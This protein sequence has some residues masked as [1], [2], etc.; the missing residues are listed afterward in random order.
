MITGYASAMQYEEPMRGLDYSAAVVLFGFG[1]AASVYTTEDLPRR[2]RCGIV[3]L[4]TAFSFLLF[5]EGFV[6]HDAGH[7]WI[8]FDGML[9]ALL[10]FQWSAGRRYIASE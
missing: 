5:K 3:G 8:F 2:A 1:L 10:A 6:R 7:A 9:A 4:W